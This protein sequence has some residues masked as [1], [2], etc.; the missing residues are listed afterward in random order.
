MMKLTAPYTGILSFLIVL[1]TMPLGHAAMILMGKLLG[2]GWLY[3]AAFLLGVVG[4]GILLAGIFAKG[5]KAATF[6]GLFGGLFVWTGWI[7]FAYVYYAQ[8]LGVP[9]LVEQGEV[10]TKP[11]YLLMP[12]SVGFWA[13]MML[14]YLFGTRSGCNFF[15]WIQKKI[16]YT[17]TTSACGEEQPRL[18]HPMF[19]NPAITTFMEL[20]MLLWTCYLVLLFSYDQNFLG[21]RHPVTACIAF[22][23]LAWSIYL[24]TRLLRIKQIAYAIRY[25]IPTVIIFWN[26]VEILGRW[27][28]LT[29]IWIE[30]SHYW[31]EMTAMCV[32][33][34]LLF[35]VLISKRKRG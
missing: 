33:F 21:D 10:V 28:L 22:G 2:P 5:E 25:A 34:A 6:A 12:S 7:E 18:L 14:F 15:N 3:P 31:V 8:R 30:P 29:E 32:A 19:R 26:F 35:M 20:N 11:E 17:Q 13:I 4:V 24:F 1:F 16:H 23:S 9:P 27:D